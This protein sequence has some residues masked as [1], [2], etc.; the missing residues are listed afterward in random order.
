MLPKLLETRLNGRVG[1]WSPEIATKWSQVVRTMEVLPEIVEWAD[2]RRDDLTAQQVF[3]YRAAGRKWRCVLQWR[4]VPV[5]SERH[6][7]VEAGD[8]L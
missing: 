4:Q 8:D 6:A 1:V 5:R 7:A 2:Y 3:E